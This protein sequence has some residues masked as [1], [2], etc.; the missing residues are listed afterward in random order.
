[1]TRPGARRLDSSCGEQD[2]LP[3]AKKFRLVG[4]DKFMSELTKAKSYMQ[5]LNLWSEANIIGPLSISDPNGFDWENVVEQVKRA[6]REKVLE[7]F[8]NGL[9]AKDG[10]L[11][12]Q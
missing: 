5:E 11:K 9:K 7:S 2:K 12:L 10:P 8:K 1:M 4:K 3:A 6:I